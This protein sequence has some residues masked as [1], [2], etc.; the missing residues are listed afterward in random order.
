MPRSSPPSGS[1][2][3]PQRAFVRGAGASAPP[4]LLLIAFLGLA[5]CQCGG[6]GETRTTRYLLLDDDA[7]VGEW[8]IQIASA[9]SIVER[10]RLNVQGGGL[11]EVVDLRHEQIIDEDGALLRSRWTVAAGEHVREGNAWLD[12]GTLFVESPGGIRRTAVGDGEARARLSLVLEA[13]QYAP[14][15]EFSGG[16][17]D[18]LAGELRPVRI[19]VGHSETVPAATVTGRRLVVEE[20]GRTSRW[21]VDER[22]LPLRIE[23]P[24]G[25]V[26]VREDVYRH[27]SDPG[28]LP[29][30]PVDID[31]RSRVTTAAGVRLDPSAP[32]ASYRL[33]GVDLATLRGGRQSIVDEVLVVV[34]ELSAGYERL[35]ESGPP[36]DRTGT[37]ASLSESLAATD[38]DALVRDAVAATLRAVRLRVT[39]GRVI[40][41][42]SPQETLSAGVGDCTELSHTLAAA[43]GAAGVPARI[44]VGFALVDGAPRHHAWVEYWDDGWQTVDPALGQLPADVTHVRLAAGGDPSVIDQVAPLLGGLVIESVE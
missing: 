13:R 10:T 27:P 34:R 30:R 24:D 42:P 21:W 39:P 33:G 29:E 43:L 7:V 28:P 5:G 36:A 40:G 41:R 16:V 12:D 19:R 32:R 25:P 8:T 20:A 2:S 15:E 6:D 38:P 23:P 4:L 9:D 18:P 3:R 35:G 44:A 14:G 11:G 17:F 26:A 22:G 37:T 31:A 1:E